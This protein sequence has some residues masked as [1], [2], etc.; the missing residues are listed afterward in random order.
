MNIYVRLSTFPLSFESNMYVY[1]RHSKILYLLSI[2][3]FNIRMVKRVFLFFHSCFTHLFL[4]A[5]G[6]RLC[7][8]GVKVLNMK[9]DFSTGGTWRQAMNTNDENLRFFLFGSV[10]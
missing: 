3:T 1:C 9:M 7:W 6:R 10:I 2:Y 4:V 5:F 8:L